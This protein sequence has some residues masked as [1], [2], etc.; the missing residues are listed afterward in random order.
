MQSESSTSP[1]LIFLHVGKVAV[2]LTFI[3]DTAGFELVFG[4]EFEASCGALGE[5]DA[6]GA[7]IDLHAAFGVV[8]ADVE[9]IG[10]G[11]RVVAIDQAHLAAWWFRTRR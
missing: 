9:A 2:D 1:I 7:G 6:G 5:N 3:A 8:E 4:G 10:D 11:V